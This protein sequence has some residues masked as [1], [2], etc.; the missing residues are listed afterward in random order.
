M[1]SDFSDAKEFGQEPCSLRKTE[2]ELPDAAAVKSVFGD[3]LQ[4]F[5]DAACVFKPYDMPSA[6][7]IGVSEKR[8]LRICII[9]NRCLVLHGELNGVLVGDSGVYGTGLIG[10]GPVI[11]VKR[12]AENFLWGHGGEQIELFAGLH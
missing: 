3:Q 11:A 12:K 10:Q 2:C 8:G 1:M 4:F 6:L 5:S 7:F 9:L